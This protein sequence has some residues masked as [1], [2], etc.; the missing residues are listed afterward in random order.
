MSMLY[1]RGIFGAQN[2]EIVS[3]QQVV[4][5]CIW[6]RTYVE[7]MILMRLKENY[8]PERWL[9]TQSCFY[10]F[11]EEISWV[12]CWDQYVMINIIKSDTKLKRK[13][14]C[15]LESMRHLNSCRWF[16]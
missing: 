3:V 4:D 5:F 9:M 10:R 15:E 16:G 1:W 14:I 6:I 7:F 11:A 8:N 13:T 2:F 12:E